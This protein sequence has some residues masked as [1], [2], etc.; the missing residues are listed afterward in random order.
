MSP[1]GKRVR[2]CPQ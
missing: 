1:T 2:W